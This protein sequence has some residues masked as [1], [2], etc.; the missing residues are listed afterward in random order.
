MRRVDGFEHRP[1]NHCGSTSLANLATYYGW[2]YDEPTC[3]G[4][5]SGLGFTFLELPDGAERVMLGRPLWLEVA[6]FERLAIGHEHHTGEGW[7]T[8]RGRIVDGVA[9]DEPVLLFTDL[10][11]MDYFDTDTH[12]APHSLL[13]IGYDVDAD[14]V[15][16]SD[17]E[18]P[19]PQ[20]LA[21]ERLA[22][23]LDSPYMVPE[24]GRTLVVTD[25]DPGV[26][27]AAAAPA[28]VAETARYMLDPDAVDR[29]LGPGT[30]GLAGV[31][32][33]ADDVPSWTDLADPSWTARFAY[34][35]VERR[36]TGGGCFR[37]MYAQFLAAAVEADDRLPADA[38]D[39][40]SE[41]AADWTAA[42]ETLKAASERDD[43][44]E[45]EPLFA[46]AAEQLHDLAD[47][48]E[49]LF[50]DLLAALE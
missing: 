39:R 13:A 26:G 21:G 36:G 6:F 37:R 33:L 17:N 24:P 1:G 41:I 49:A 32:A 46:D 9:R 7:E 23:A 47:R 50:A 35:N 14:T 43:E 29:E 45:M 4:L 18:F 8:I 48:E 30:H 12:F 11:Y 19:E 27:F 40:M 42:G 22:A 15:L 38:P 44:G 34:Q 3:F 16:L 5:G 31:R 20:T 10:Y 2:G 25:P 28:A